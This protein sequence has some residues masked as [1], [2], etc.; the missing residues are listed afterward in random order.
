[1]AN[2]YSVQVAC[3][4]VGTGLLLVG[5]GASGQAL[6]HTL[7]S[8]NGQLFGSFGLAVAGAGDVNGDGRADVVVGADGEEGPTGGSAGRAYVF[9]GVTGQV[10]H[11]L[12]APNHQSGNYFGTS[13][14]GVGDIDADG[15]A[16]V[17]I[18]ARAAV[19]PGNAP[20]GRA[21]VFGGDDGLLLRD[22]ISPDAQAG[23]SFGAAVAAAGDVNCDLVPD[24]L[25][26]AVG[27]NTS[28]GDDAGRAYLFSG[29][30]GE[31]LR[32]LESP[33]AQAAGL[34]GQ[35]VAGVGDMD[36]DGCGDVAVGAVNEHPGNG[37]RAGRAHVLSGATGLA[38]RSLDSPLAQVGGR[39]GMS[40]SG[41]GDVD[42]DAVPDL[43]VGSPG[44]TPDGPN[45]GRAYLFSGATGA[46]LVTLESPNV[47]PTGFF[48]GAVAAAGDL[49]GDGLADVLV[50]GGNEDTAAGFGAGRAYA[51]DGTGGLLFAIESPNGQQ[52][53]TFG[54]AIAGAGD[55]DADGRPELVIGAMGETTAAGSFA[56]RAYVVPAPIVVAGEPGAG[57][58]GL[59]VEIS[60]NPAREVATVR[61]ALPHSGAV[62]LSVVDAL[63]RELLRPV[64]GQRTAG[65]HVVSVRGLSAGVY[66]VRLVAGAGVRTVL[67]TLGR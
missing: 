39:F 4:V 15:R 21:F 43:L 7:E 42:G 2:R 47:E 22:L 23:G 29:S 56:G 52:S 6:P 40:V 63:G 26:A 30:T 17:L 13:V 34:F 32:T 45:S 46:H 54:S 31:L 41:A 24:L 51:F 16:D 20:A 8:P 19:S 27:E 65:R 38:I 58:A 12:E 55:V 35:A 5:A 66:L 62:R 44:E 48:G 61:F 10:V 33:S 18:G 14:A 36:G 11:T 37:V 3:V 60:P 28:A 64:D 67:L 59:V 53:G 9:D 57:E 25:V 50:G 49:A 1:M